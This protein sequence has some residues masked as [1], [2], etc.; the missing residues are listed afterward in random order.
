MN[1]SVMPKAGLAHATAI[2]NQATVVF[3]ADAAILTPTSRTRSTRPRRRVAWQ[4]RRRVVGTTTWRCHGRAATA[5]PA[6]RATRCTS[7]TAAA[8]YV[9]WQAENVTATSA[10]SIGTSGHAYAFY[11]QRD[12]RRRQRRGGQVDRRSDDRR[13]RPVHRPDG[14]TGGGTSAAAVA[15]SAATRQRDA[16]L[17][18]ARDPRGGRL[19]I[20]CRR[21]SSVA[22]QSGALK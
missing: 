6:S 15:P 3:D 20:L 5:A 22:A 8:P 4:R 17:A 21:P 7:P 14:G 19:V 11:V 13:Q 16:G 9:A 2:G 12:R 18:D 1:V 10:V